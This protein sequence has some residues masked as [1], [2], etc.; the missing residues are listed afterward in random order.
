MTIISEQVVKLCKSNHNFNELYY[1]VL[2]PKINHN[3]ALLM[4]NILK[5]KDIP[6]VCLQVP[7]YSEYIKGAQKNIEKVLDIWS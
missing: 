2:Y 6:E 1:D 5:Q 3:R 4:N 7:L